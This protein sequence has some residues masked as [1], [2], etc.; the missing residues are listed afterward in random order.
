[1]KT[2]PEA[3]G[4]YGRPFPRSQVSTPNGHG[5]STADAPNMGKS[6]GTGG[7][8]SLAMTRGPPSTFPG[9]ANTSRAYLGSIQYARSDFSSVLIGK[10]FGPEKYFC[11]TREGIIFGKLCG[12]PKECFGHLKKMLLGTYVTKTGLIGGPCPSLTCPLMGVRRPLMPKIRRGAWSN[13]RPFSLYG[14]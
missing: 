2:V 11:S 7:Y 10:V 12:F 1:M 8:V 6:A 13:T 3:P 9:H 14:I 4:I 5:H